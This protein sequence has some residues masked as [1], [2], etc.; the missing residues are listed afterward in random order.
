[1]GRNGTFYNADGRVQKLDNYERITLHVGSRFGLLPHMFWYVVEGIDLANF[2]APA[3]VPAANEE[4]VP[5]SNEEEV[6]V[7]SDDD[8]VIIVE[9]PLIH[10]R[11]RRRFFHRF[12]VNCYK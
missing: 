9:P 8:D 7:Q 2:P 1:M 12:L 3:L 4:E 5:E 6:P 10:Q 11:S